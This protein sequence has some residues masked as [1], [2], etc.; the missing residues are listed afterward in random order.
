MENVTSISGPVNGPMNS[1]LLYPNVAPIE[2]FHL[3]ASIQ[4]PMNDL[5]LESPPPPPPPG[6]GPPHLSPTALKQQQQESL[7]AMSIYNDMPLP[8]LPPGAPYTP[9]NIS[10]R[11]PTPQQ[12][13]HPGGPPVELPPSSSP[14]QQLSQ[15]P[16]QSFI[17]RQTAPTLPSTD[18]TG[19]NDTTERNNSTG[20]T[21]ASIAAPVPQFSPPPVPANAPTTPSASIPG[22][23]PPSSGTAVHPMHQPAP[24]SNDISTLSY[25]DLSSSASTIQMIATTGRLPRWLQK[26]TGLQYLVCKNMGLTVVDDWL[27]VRLTNLKVIRLND[28]RISTWPGHLAR[29]AQYG[30]LK[31]LDMDGNPCIENL[32]IKSPSFKALYCE[33]GNP[34]ITVSQLKRYKKQLEDEITESENAASGG[35]T[36]GGTSGGSSWKSGIFKKKKKSDK[37]DHEVP[38]IYDYN[39][40]NSNSNHYYHHNPNGG[41]QAPIAPHPVAAESEVGEDEDVEDMLTSLRPSGNATLLKKK[42]S[43]TNFMR[44]KEQSP[45]SSAPTSGIASPI[46]RQAPQLPPIIDRSPSIYSTAT[47]STITTTPDKWANQRMEPS[48]IEK[49]KVLLQ[50]LVDI[51]ELTTHEICVPK[52]IQEDSDTPRSQTGRSSATTHGKTNSVDVLQHYLDSNIETANQGKNADIL[53][54]LEDF[55]ADEH[56]FIDRLLEFQ[57]I[58]VQDTSRPAR[59]ASPCFKF[60]PEICRLHSD[61]LVGLFEAAL[62]RLKQSRSESNGMSELDGDD[63]VLEML[64]SRIVSLS[65]E[66][67]WYLEYA[68]ISEESK[69]KVRTWIK[70]RRIDHSAFVYGSALPGYAPTQ[71]HPDSDV[72]EWLRN[73]LKLSN[74]MLRS[75]TDYMQLPYDRLEKYK[76]FFSKF[77]HTAPSMQTAYHNMS[78]LLSEIEERKPMAERRRRLQD[79]QKMFKMKD[80]YGE[81]LSDLSV[82]LQSRVVL[83]DAPNPPPPVIKRIQNIGTVKVGDCIYREGG[84]RGEPQPKSVV[85]RV[86]DTTRPPT[87]TLMRIIVFEHTVVI[88]DEGKRTILRQVDKRSVTAM[89]PRLLPNLDE[90][91]SGGASEND[92]SSMHTKTTVTTTTASG[93]GTGDP[94]TVMKNMVRIGFWDELCVWY[95]VARSNKGGDKKAFINSF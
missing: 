3:I 95:A 26:C 50:L 49:T 23:A 74:H 64:G 28:N 72:A 1:E 53:E 58:Y 66:F 29:L 48:E 73:C 37:P 85:K 45:S 80:Q 25:L 57:K 9:P 79:L 22:A 43:V 17:R 93:S 27:S 4:P 63:L 55:I 32:F 31:V 35:A 51:H 36:S 41:L 65:E 67:H 88:A 59:K 10:P 34:A 44:S 83:E 52:A 76:E 12:Q 81:F 2:D 84:G 16:S 13:Q 46:P 75:C 21:N 19:N 54:S 39:D 6:Q 86:Y 5:N 7:S 91:S 62:Q 33:N 38:V 40:P 77:S 60:L 61:T 47:S 68:L 78:S 82:V 56:A 24:A 90:L 94:A 14:L 42:P 69:R 18:N 11:G 70:I 87:G 20:S 71:H 89:E 15:R 30:N 92:G 8:P